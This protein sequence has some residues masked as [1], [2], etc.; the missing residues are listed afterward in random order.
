[1]IANDV[2]V[3]RIHHCFETIQGLIMN[4]MMMAVEVYPVK[5]QKY[6]Y[7]RIIVAKLHMNVCKFPTHVYSCTYA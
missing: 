4:T 2:Q 3:V 7:V 1:M 5:Q 6:A